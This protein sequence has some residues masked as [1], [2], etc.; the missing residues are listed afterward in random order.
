MFWSNGRQ[1][2]EWPCYDVSVVSVGAGVSVASVGALSLGSAASAAAA[3]V[4]ADSVAAV[5]VTEAVGAAVEMGRSGT[6]PWGRSGGSWEGSMVG[7]GGNG[8]RPGMF[9]GGKDEKDGTERKKRGKGEETDRSGVIS[10]F[11]GSVQLKRSDFCDVTKGICALRRVMNHFSAS[12]PAAGKVAMFYL[13]LR[14]AA[15]VT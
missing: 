5:T 1:D 15:P 7:R 9:R 12:S 4:A 10:F 13:R 14:L 8:V 2:V 6:A 3:M 11:F